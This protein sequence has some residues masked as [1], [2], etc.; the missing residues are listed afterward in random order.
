MFQ[1]VVRNVSTLSEE[2][3]TFLQT[4]LRNTCD[5]Y[6]KLRL[7]SKQQT[8]L[9]N[10][11]KNK[12]IVI[13]KQDKGKGVVILDRN[14]YVEKCLTMLQTPQF[15]KLQS[16]P[17]GKTE[18]QVQRALRKIKTK[19]PKDVYNKLYPTGSRPGQFY[20]LSKIHKLKEG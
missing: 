13:M 5:K 10:L 15:K 18:G 11:M 3:K 8:V 4:K 12:H 17:T 20:G 2:E 1:D 16:D 19:L 14:K 9:K 6:G 7:P